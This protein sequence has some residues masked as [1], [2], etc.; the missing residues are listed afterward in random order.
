MPQ[1][2][3]YLTD[4]NGIFVG[5]AQDET[6]MTGCTVILCPEWCY[7]RRRSTRWR[8]WNPGNRSFAP[9]ASG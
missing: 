9:N 3:N 5:H 7:C 1:L 8:S 4:I 6:A 2:N